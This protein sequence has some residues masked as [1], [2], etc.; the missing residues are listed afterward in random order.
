[1]KLLKLDPHGIQKSFYNKA[2]IENWGSIKILIS[3]KTA[4]A[5]IDSKGNFYRL[6]NDYSSTTMNHINAFRMEYGLNKIY[7]KD[8]VNLKVD[9][10]PKCFHKDTTFDMQ[11]YKDK[12][13]MLRWERLGVW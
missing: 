9:T 2:R 1:M 13:E 12:Q 7:K 5:Y 8:W 3:Y 4:V 6:W 10:L 11:E